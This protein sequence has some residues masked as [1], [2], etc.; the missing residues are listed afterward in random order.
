VLCKNS[1]EDRFWFNSEKLF[2]SENV[3]SNIAHVQKVKNL[4]VFTRALRNVSR[5]KIRALLVII[6]LSLSVAILIAIPTGIMANQEAAEQLSANY[7]NYLADMENEITTAA[8]LLEVSLSP[9]FTAAGFGGRGRPGGG[10]SGGFMSSESFFNE[11]VASDI[12][13]IEGVAAVIPVLEKSEGT[14]ETRSTQFGEF[15]FLRP[16]YT[17]VG[18]PLDDSILS[19]YPVLASGIIEG[20]TLVEGDSGVVLLSLN[21]TDYFGVGVSDQVNILGSDFTVV[22]IYTTTT[23]QEMNHLY[24]SLSEAQAITE[25]E[26]EI[27]RIDVYAENEAIVDAVYN[28]IT[29]MYPEFYVNTAEARLES[30]TAMA[31]RQVQV[32]ED[33]EA[34][35]VETQAVAYMEIGIAVVGTSLIVL[36]TMLYTVR[37]R[38]REIGVLKAIGFS[39][40]SIMS[41]F[42]LEGMFLSIVAGL[43]G[44]V[45]G[46]I[47][48]PIITQLLLTGF[49]SNSGPETAFAGRQIG[50]PGLTVEATIVTP[51]VELLL[52]VFAGAILLGVLGS[53]YPSW[54]ASKTSPMEA[55]RHE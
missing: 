20:R 19:N 9:E 15:E 4:G 28:D 38:T 22:G 55:L 11:T 10:F 30:I 52:V 25:I 40:G 43:L 32:L 33:A 34:D 50:I 49:A 14:L 7:D 16:E 37:E 31:E 13:N 21:N 12:N 2:N 51:S 35:L 24:M 6:A 42:M 27:S 53:I 36:F 45:I 41:Q 48:A 47:G 54:R 1:L 5:R 26:G 39:N 17:I 29:A 3:D 18:V 8:T 44:V 23:T 46:T